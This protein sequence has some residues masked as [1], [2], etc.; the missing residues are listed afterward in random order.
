MSKP[1]NAIR[2]SVPEKLFNAFNHLFFILAGITTLLPFVNLLAKSL[3]SESAVI[4]GT[5]GL[6]PVGWQTGTYRYVLQNAMFLNAFQ[7]SVLVTVVGTALSLAMTTITAYPLSKPR[8]RGRK[9]FLL[10]FIFTML[11]S[12]GL[13]PTYLLMHNLG[14]VNSLPVLFLPAMVNVFNMLIIKNYFEGLPDSLEE[15][16]KLDG[17]GNIRILL[18]VVLPLSLPVLATIALFF[19]VAFW[20]DYFAPMIYITNPSLKPLQLYLKELLVASGGEFLKD[21]VDAALNTT[22]QSIQAA[23][24]LLA[25]VPILLVYPFLQK[26]FVKGVLIGS[27]KG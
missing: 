8:L 21:N 5:V 27:V 1:S 11:F 22:P 25:T 3:S 12:G 16:A 20:N 19:A 17:A 10:L 6:W 7:V 18:Y 24:I 14:L 2:S 15:S 26:Y 4:S 13:I 23:S 9:W